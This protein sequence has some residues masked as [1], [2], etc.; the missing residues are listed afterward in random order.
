MGDLDHLGATQLL[1]EMAGRRVSAVELAEAAIARIDRYDG[2]LNAVCVRDFDRALDAARAADAARARGDAG[3]LCGVP[4]TVKESFR[5][6]GLP[7]TW[8]YPE[9]A[10]FRAEEDAVAVQRVRAAG[11][12]VLGV[13]N[14]PLA[15]GDLQTYND[16]YGTTANPWDPARSPGGSSGG[17]AAAL[18][19]ATGR[20]R[21]ARTSAGPCATP[22][23]SAACTRTSRRSG[24]S[25][26]AGTPRRGC[27]RCPPRTSSP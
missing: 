3:P 14:V 5:V 6:A 7:S 15:L 22:P 20:C 9:S 1:D 18:A 12:V 8:G 11:A 21:S 13:T 16:I 27:P 26:S 4:M 17:S 19:A 10:G 23:T 25:R 24:C 2:V